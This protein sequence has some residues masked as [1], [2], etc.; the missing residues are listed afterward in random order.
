M[1]TSENK[2][3]QK[4]LRLICGLVY[5]PRELPRVTRV[6]EVLQMVSET[7][8]TISR[9]CTGQLRRIRWHTS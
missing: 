7:I 6:D 9:A 5:G 4:R 2:N 3:V 1:Y 8:L